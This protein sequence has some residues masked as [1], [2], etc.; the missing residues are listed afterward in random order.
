MFHIECSID[1]KNDLNIVCTG[2]SVQEVEG[3]IKI[4]TATLRVSSRENRVAS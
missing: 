2:Q 1:E 3:K 4:V